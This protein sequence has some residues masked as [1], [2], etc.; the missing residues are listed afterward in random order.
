MGGGKL[1]NFI[2]FYLIKILFAILDSDNSES[3]SQYKLF[4]W[5]D[6]LEDSTFARDSNEFS[7]TSAS[8]N[9]SVIQKFKKET[10]KL[11]NRT[12]I[13]WTVRV[14]QK[15]SFVILPFFWPL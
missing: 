11:Q 14:K 15:I 10:F 4:S 2:L 7:K 1:H 5:V 8:A 3:N 12:I 6:S 13:I 9:E